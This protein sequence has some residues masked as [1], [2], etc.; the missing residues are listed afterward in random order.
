MDDMNYYVLCQFVW[1]SYILTT[2]NFCLYN[3]RKLMDYCSALLIVNFK[4]GCSLLNSLS[5]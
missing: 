3:S 4:D 2:T 1:F 5:E